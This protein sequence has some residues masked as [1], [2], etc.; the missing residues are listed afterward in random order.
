M[1]WFVSSTWDVHNIMVPLVGHA[2]GLSASSIGGIL[3]AFALAA[4]LV[5]LVMP[6]IAMRVREW[7]LLATALAMAAV[8]MAIYPLTE[9]VVSMALCSVLIGMAIGG[10]QPLVLALLHHATPPGMH[11][12]AAALRLLMI[13]A[14]SISMP[15]LAGSAGGLI[16]VAGV[17]WA[18]GLSLLVGIRMAVGLR[19]ML[20]SRGPTP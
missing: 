5:R 17:F 8:L 1:N 10:V 20:D 18:T 16:G 14:S 4:A 15:L 7:L 13:N 11:G 3:G 9:S 2:R 6:Y 19:S 12:Q